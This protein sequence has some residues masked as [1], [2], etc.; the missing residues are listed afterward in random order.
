MN[1]R[2]WIGVVGSMCFALLLFGAT[3]TRH[4]NQQVSSA[5]QRPS[6]SNI[7]YGQIPLSFEANSGQTDAAVKFLARGNRY[8]LFLTKDAQAVLVMK[9]TSTVPPARSIA[10]RTRSQIKVEQSSPDVLRVGMIGAS[11]NPETEALAKQE[12]TASY[13][14]G[15]DTN[16]WQT[17]IPLFGRIR[18]RQVY[19][20]IDVV[21]Y[22]NQRNLEQDFVVSPGADP[23]SIRMIVRGAQRLSINSRGDLVVG[24]TNGDVE[25]HKPVA[26]QEV[27]GARQE[28]ASGFVLGRAHE[29]RFQ[30][31]E[32]DSSRELVID[33]VL[34]Y[35]TLMGGNYNDGG[36]GIAADS[37]GNAY[38]HGEAQSTNFPTSAGAFQPGPV[39]S[40]G[41]FVM[42]LNTS[43]GL[44]YSTYLGG[45]GTDFAYGIAVDA[46]G[47]AYVTGDTDSP[48]FP[49]TAGAFQTTK[50]GSTSAYVAK[51]NSSGTALV[52]GSYLG[53]SAFDHGTG[54]AVDSS[55]NAYVSGFTE[56][57]DFPT[58]TGAFQTSVVAGSAHAFVVQVNSTGTALLYSTY[59]GG[60]RQDIANGVR[61]DSQGNAYVVGST[62]SGDF[63]VTAGAYQPTQHGGT[64]A[65]VTKVN[66]TGSGLAYSTY[67]GGGNEELG[68]AI[69]IDSSGNAYIAGVSDS[70]D[71]P[72][73]A[74]SFQSTPPPDFN[75]YV[76]KL[77]ATGS[78]LVYST[79]L[80]GSAS[81][82]ARAIAVDSSGNAFVAGD[83]TSTDFPTANPVQATA[84]GSL[85][86]FATVL[87]PA[88]SALVYS[89]YIG[90]SGA[91]FAWGIATDSSSNLYATGTTGST[92]FPT[93][94]GAFQTTNQ[95]FE[96]GFVV[97][98]SGIT[99]SS[100][101]KGDVAGDGDEKDDRGHHTHFH[102]C[103]SKK[104][105]EFEDHDDGRR[106]K[107]H[108]GAV[109]IIGNQ[110]IMGGSGTLDD[111]TA[112]N[113][114]AVAIGN[115]R[116]TG[117]NRFLIQWAS[118]GGSSFQ[119]GGAL[120]KGTLIVRSDK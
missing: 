91:E 36:V 6:A 84:G 93:S 43:G 11:P 66:P 4:R 45:S 74:G 82:E 118:S 35:S 116:T 96:D 52:Y 94:A 90:G 10:H 114:V 58:T 72:T 54:V 110:A 25:F 101:G 71:M 37:A 33:P 32:Y 56:S 41:T 55:G 70:T 120:T 2:V 103:R 57:T 51:L 17:N 73:T 13:F 20:G 19:P 112:V 30:L 50:P 88:G 63:P 75:A 108:L 79:F 119:S 106:I 81:E 86:G 100:S 47:N 23:R 29:I 64:N 38:I 40:E 76:A 26:Y 21:Y 27:K 5:Q 83:T 16:K 48:N 65:F 111:G 107:G 60:S 98:V 34:T 39:G 22:G 49:T 97:K 1:R 85:D 15:N 102:V 78:A 68:D 95:G 53:G 46:G 42:K 109:A 61:V 24:M 92:D 117:G 104:E 89:S 18:M 31:G 3:R 44:V 87:N 67:F 8:T 12:A 14:L 69:A 28:I 9:K 115:A 105:V 62:F 99:C 113:F 77:N 7:S 80:G 59:L